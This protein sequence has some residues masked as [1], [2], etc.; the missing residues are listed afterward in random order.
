MKLFVKNMVCNR[1]VMV[2]NQVLK[3]LEIN[4]LSIKLGEVDIDKDLSDDELN[5]LRDKLEEVGFEL[6]DDRKQQLVE[7]VKNLL[8]GQIH[9]SEDIVMKI[10]F[11]AFLQ[12]ALRIDY[13]YLSA[14]FSQTEG[15]TIE[16]FVILQRI[17]RAKELLIYNE[18]TL[19]EIAYKLGYSSVQHLSTQFK[20][21]T[22]LTPSHFKS[23]KAYRRSPLDGL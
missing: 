22:G 3:Q 4:P 11:S 2:V 19:S 20:K 5:V 18:F 9:G 21:V 17:E 15:I 7:K 13:S 6:L 16:Q 14:L 1:C 23:I 12:E 8:I 10:N